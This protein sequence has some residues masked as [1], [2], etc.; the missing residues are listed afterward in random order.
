MIKPKKKSLDKGLESLIV[1]RFVAN[2]F[3]WLTYFYYIDCFT[4]Y[5]AQ[6]FQDDNY[7]SKPSAAYEWLH[8]FDRLNSAVYASQ[9]WELSPYLSSPILAMHHLF[10][11][12]SRP[13]WN[14]NIPNNSFNN[15]NN[16]NNKF[17]SHGH[18]ATS[19]RSNADVS[20]GDGGGGGSGTTATSQPHPLALPTA[21]YTALE[22][23]KQSKETLAHLHAG[24]TLPVSRMY[25]APDLL[26]TEL[27]PYVM[28]ILAPAVNPVVV[29][30]S[31][32]SSGPSS[33]SSS[34]HPGSFAS[35]RKASEKAMVARAVEC[36]GATGIRFSKVRVGSTADGEPYG[37]SRGENAGDGNAYAKR[38]FVSEPLA[39]VYRMCPPVDEVVDFGT[40]GRGSSNSSSSSSKPGIKAN[41]ATANT[42]APSN[43]RSNSSAPN[44]VRYAVRQVLDQEWK[45]EEARL[46]SLAR[47]RRGGV[48]AHASTNSGNDA[49]D[50]D[51]D[52]TTALQDGMSG[53]GSAE[54]GKGKGRNTFS[55]IATGTAVKRDFF[56]RP[57][58]PA[59]A[60]RPG[61]SNAGKGSG[62]GDE[63]NEAD[64]PD[65]LGRDKSHLKK[66]KKNNKH[67]GVVE[68]AK[69]AKEARSGGGGV[70]G[71]I[72]VSFNEGYSNAVRK[73]IT[74]AELLASF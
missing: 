25:S 73:P 40:M 37:N 8:F 63:I 70:G 57:I 38:P 59:P 26:A 11:S 12:P 49:A 51:V 30:G 17:N 24:M 42:G 7:L 28:R 10:A 64:V 21:P 20:T 36:M 45:R 56:G 13:S 48:R 31:G 3:L 66:P 39:W 58:M 16:N 22:L 71:R 60:T 67:S 5:P 9:E 29:G 44:T 14:A 15:N 19:A 32:L 35:V 47:M 18:S 74:L 33:S 1:S 27:A 52:A 34:S 4:Q 54:D 72:W 68:D 2:I 55:S 53:N 50:V 61:S 62:N 69:R 23:T 41:S 43:A 46:A 6:P 65:S